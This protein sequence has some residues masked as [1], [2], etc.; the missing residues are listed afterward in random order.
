MHRLAAGFV[1]LAITL[2]GSAAS[3]L[4]VDPNPINNTRVDLDADL[5]VLSV[6]GDTITFQL[7]VHLG[8]ITA[9]EVT[10]LNDGGSGF[11]FLAGGSTNAGTGDVAM[12]PFDNGLGGVITFF[13]TVNA[14]ETSDELVVQF[15]DAIQADWIGAINFSNGIVQ[16]ESYTITPEPGSLALL[17][18]S[19]PLLAA[20]RW[21]R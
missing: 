3:A 20:R 11:N 19:L 21:R 14:G 1:V 15:E 16:N 4:S 6:V 12:N 5:N 18:A 10:L 17:L 7:E 8:T 9:V 13:G 2:L